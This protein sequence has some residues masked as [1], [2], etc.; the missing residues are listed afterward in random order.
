MSCINL[1]EKEVRTSD[2]TLLLFG[3]Y[4]LLQYNTINYNSKTVHSIIKFTHEFWT[5][6]EEIAE[7]RDDKEGEK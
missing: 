6:Q 7:A 2:I 3:T 1:K 4:V 5:Y